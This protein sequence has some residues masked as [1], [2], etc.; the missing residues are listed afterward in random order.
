MNAETV[1][2]APAA[3]QLPDARVADMTRLRDL[4][5]AA[6]ERESAE[7]AIGYYE[8]VLALA[9]GMGN[10]E[11]EGE[12]LIREADV[13]RSAGHF[14][15]ADARL[16]QVLTIARASTVIGRRRRSPSSIGA[17]RQPLSGAQRLLKD[18]SIRPWRWCE[19]RRIG[20][21]S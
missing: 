8:Q 17:S 15:S 14:E 5:D 3:S 21:W 9:R 1:Y 6:A 4:G 13:H 11:W 20:V 16:D 19:K 10:R 2:P 12:T 18:T 7:A